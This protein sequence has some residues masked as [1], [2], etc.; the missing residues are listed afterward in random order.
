M[1][2]RTPLGLF[3]VLWAIAASLHHLEARPFAGLPLYPF[4]LLLFV[5]PDRLWAIALFALV[6]AA[7]SFLDLPTAANHTV[8]AL[9]VDSALLVGCAQALR[10]ATTDQPRRLWESVRGPLQATVVVVY[11]FAV[12]DKVNSSFLDPDVSCASLQLVKMF[13]LHGLQPPGWITS[14]LGFNIT[15]TLV[16]ESAIVVLLLGRGTAH[17]AA[18]IGLAFHTLLAWA[19][20]Y[21]F[22]TVVLALYLFFFPWE[23][24]QADLERLP[25]AVLA[26]STACFVALC[27]TSV[28]F[29]GFRGGAPLVTGERFTLTADTLLCLFWTLG[30]WPILFPLFSRGPA[31]AW[32]RRWSG[33]SVTW[34][35][36]V[37]AF[38]NGATSYLG[39]RTVANY[40]MFSN[41]RTEGGQTN[42]L[43]VPAGLFFVAGYQNDLARVEFL[44]GVPPAEWPW[45]VRLGGGPQWL[46]RNSR[47][48]S[49]IPARVPF[50]ELRRTL[51][52]WRAAGITG[53]SIVY[54]H[55]GRRHEED[56][57]FAVVEIA[58]PM[59]LWERKLMAFRAVEDDGQE[60]TCR[61]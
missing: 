40:S 35:I 10:S 29:L 39:L 59:P 45:W 1:R 53:I 44:G 33:A 28:T 3:S 31:E 17:V 43:L 11:S 42:H 30:I 48:L 4:A 37:L 51:W 19:S 23:K 61:W 52:L 49:E 47:W 13:S 34:L 27:A 54:E 24:L 5:F 2:L 15:L 14:V 57:A 26:W 41:L 32:R 38:A 9:L 60:S 7:F 46:R 22:A 55:D 8:L 50:E 18:R 12:L 56:D 58:R 21:D 25:R 16:A 36:P 6:H 20:F